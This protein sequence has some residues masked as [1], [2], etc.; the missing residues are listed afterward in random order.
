M[1]GC[2][3]TDKP[4]TSKKA[5]E[6]V[7]K[8]YIELYNSFD[9]EGMSKALNEEIVFQNISNGEVTLETNGIEAFKKQAQNAK[10]FFKTR[11]QTIT[12]IQFVDDIAESDINYFGILSKD[13]PNGMKAG[14][15]LPLKGKSV[16]HFK[17]EEIIKIQDKS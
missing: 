17:G 11:E 14:D 2:Q 8:D 12:D 13:L 15:T 10:E 16:F 5:K 9:V 1:V 3:Q 4:M 7:I 6:K